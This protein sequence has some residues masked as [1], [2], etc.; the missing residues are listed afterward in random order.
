MGFFSRAAI[1]AAAMLVAP[2]SA[3][4]NQIE[5]RVGEVEFTSPPAELTQRDWLMGQWVGVGIRGAP[6]MESWLPPT[7][8][9]MVGTFVQENADGTIMFTEHMYLMEEDGSLV[10]RLKHFNA[11]LTAWE[12]KEGMVTF[13]LLAIEPCAAYFNALTLRCDEREDGK[14]GLVAAV[15]MKSDN[16]EPQELLF[17]FARV[18]KGPEPAHCPAAVTTLEINECYAETLERAEARMSQ[19]LDAALTRISGEDSQTHLMRSTQEGFTAYRGGECGGVHE[20]FQDGTV[21][22]AMYLDCAIRLT[23][24]RTHTIWRN[25]LTHMDSS[26]PVLPEPEPTI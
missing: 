17:R 8:G 5:T 1:I 7:G 14:D 23:D 20:R 11:D 21:R 12:D 13:R 10:L 24:E 9:T 4:S 6:A 3:Q 15:R 18:T 25:W 26:A 16:P 2:L 22:T 19:Y